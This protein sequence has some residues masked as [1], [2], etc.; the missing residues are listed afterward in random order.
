M[1][2]KEKEQNNKNKIKIATFEVFN[3]PIL[4]HRDVIN[5]KVIQGYSL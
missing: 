4:R 2:K 5:H 1:A 3:C